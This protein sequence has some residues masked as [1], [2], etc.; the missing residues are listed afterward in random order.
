MKIYE[1]NF[2][3]LDK[4]TEEGYLRKVISKCEK[5]CLYNYTD[6]TTFEKKWNKYTLNSR[7]TVYEI[8]S[9]KII[10][11]AFPKFFNFSELPVSKLKN[12]L[13]LASNKY[14]IFDKADGSLGIIYNYEGKWRVN[15]RGS[16]ISD[17]AL[18]ATEMLQ[19][20]D[21]SKIPK[22]ITLL[23]EIVYPENK[24]IVNYGDKEDLILLG[25][26]NRNSQRELDWYKVIVFS[27]QTGMD[28]VATEFNKDFTDL[29]NE[30]MKWE[31]DIEGF[32]VLF[33]NGERVKVKGVEYLNVTK[34]LKGCSPLILW[35]KMINGVIDRSFLASI[36]EEIY[37]EI[38]P[39]V[40]KLEECYLIVYKE[41]VRD[42]EK[43][44]KKLG[45]MS[46]NREN[47]AKLIGLE[48]KN[49]GK[50]YLHPDCIFPFFLKGNCDKQILKK[51]KP[52]G[53]KIKE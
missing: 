33:S 34:I 27:E 32:V 19:K 26:F 35:E 23:V 51:I 37:P 39:V 11:K 43:I 16:F 53:N 38:Q 44:K 1:L 10:A 14:Q 13:K 46:F 12:Y 22:D 17:Q 15:T 40:Q 4:L 28:I 21:L 47:N 31:K 3:E 48:I 29:I 30:R 6:K 8:S 36:P 18:K 52:K 41:V 9:G 5:L 42:V 20:Y 7:G 25:A 2:K 45:I 50:D 24:I 49:S